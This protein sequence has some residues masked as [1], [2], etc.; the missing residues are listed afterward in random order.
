MKPRQL[1]PEQ[2]S[3]LFSQWRGSIPADVR[4]RRMS[5]TSVGS[6]NYRAALIHTI[7]VLLIVA[8]LAGMRAAFRAR[9]AVRYRVSGRRHARIRGGV[10]REIPRL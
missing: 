10:A 6:M 5:A 9:F 4:N 1:P 7:A 8:V 3:F 2:A